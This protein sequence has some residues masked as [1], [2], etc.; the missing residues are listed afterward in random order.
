M[1]EVV[2]IQAPVPAPAKGRR[3]QAAALLEAQNVGGHPGD[4]VALEAVPVMEGGV[5]PDTISSRHAQYHDGWYR[6]QWYDDGQ[7]SKFSKPVQVEAANSSRR[8]G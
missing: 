3:W 2:S 7:N 8:W 6:L 1:P 5:V 4:W